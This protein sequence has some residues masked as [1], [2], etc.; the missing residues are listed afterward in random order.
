MPVALDTRQLLRCVVSVK[1]TGDLLA[2]YLELIAGEDGEDVR[3]F[4][5]A[6]FVM[7]I[8][9]RYL[10][11]KLGNGFLCRPGFKRQSVLKYSRQFSGIGLPSFRS[12]I[13]AANTSIS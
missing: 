8:F 2:H 9:C 11:R 5:L 10:M 13:A 7:A 4:K 1:A 3:R 6:H 12:R